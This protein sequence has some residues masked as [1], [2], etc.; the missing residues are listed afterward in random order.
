MAKVKKEVQR[1]LKKAHP[2]G[3]DKKWPE[4][5]NR[6]DEAYGARRPFENRWLINLSFLGGRQYVFYNQSAQLLQYLVHRKNRLRVV[7]NKILP[8]YRKQISRLIRTNPR[9]SIVPN[10][11]EDSDLKAAK[12]GDKVIK[13]W[14]RN[15][16]MKKTARSLGG[17]IYS[18]GNGFLGDRWDPKAGPIIAGADGKLS[19]AGDAVVDVWSPFEVG[20]PTG[21][22]NETELEDL[23]WII[24][25]KFRPLEWFEN[26]YGAKGAKVGAE[27]RPSPYVDTSVLFGLTEG[28]SIQKVQGAVWAELRIKPCVKFPRG[29]F[30]QGANGKI[31][32]ESDYP[33]ESYH[34]EHFKDNEIPGVFWGMATT[35]AAIW[36]QKVWNRTVSDIGEFNR[37][38]ARGKWLVP[39]NSKM[40]VLPDDSHGQRLL[41]TPVMG[42]KP[43]MMDIKG[44]PAS[45]QQMLDILAREF[46]ELYS[47]HEVT[48][49][50]NRSDIRSGQMVALLLEQ[51]DY[52]NIP[53]H[54]IFEEG[55]ER[56]MGRVLQRIQKG[57]DNERVISVVGSSGEHEVFK[58]KGADL[59]NNTDVHVVR[60][61]TLPESKLAK[62]MRIKEN[63]QQGLYGDPTDEGTRER[64]LRMLDEVPDDIQDIFKETHLDRQN[65]QVENNAIATQ[66]GVSYII[67]PYD[68]HEVHLAE[69]RLFK[70]QPEYQKLKREDPSAFGQL[71]ISFFQHEQLHQ[72]FLAQQRE[73]QMKMAASMEK[74]KKGGR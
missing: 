6:M 49:G 42:H 21:G 32:E 8:R 35:E 9:M 20:G 67:N 36:L 5:K 41:Y 74:M 34:L 2:L 55:I 65:A 59:K 38:M 27:T 23:P 70:K 7:D 26:T 17:W 4:L 47:Q 37:V 10:S 64:V 57:Y 48:Q 39:R 16:W 28:S 22:I 29:L 13:W 61:S 31:L 62:Q 68:N 24:K 11:V 30:L 44:L 60:D 40:E 1:L 15:H 72:K 63:Y 46:M 69:H 50:T 25:M 51:D 19:Y 43:D 45:Y 14:W 33:F 66:P 12:I 54:A 53:T 3:P 52:G 58:F 71:E 73:A 56:S 18:C